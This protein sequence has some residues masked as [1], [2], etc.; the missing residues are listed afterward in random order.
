MTARNHFWN[1]LLKL[2]TRKACNYCLINLESFSPVML[3]ILVENVS[4]FLHERL[5]S[6]S[7][8][9]ENSNV[10]VLNLIQKLQESK[11]TISGDNLSNSRRIQPFSIVNVKKHF[12]DHLKFLKWKIEASEISDWDNLKSPS[13]TSSIKVGY[14]WKSRRF[15]TSI[16]NILSKTFA[17]SGWNLLILCWASQT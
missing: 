10:D 2:L 4:N 15:Q 12:R 9:P 16:R 8:T 17:M 5:K 1:S 3:G 11:P 14:F 6:S 7:E 13:S